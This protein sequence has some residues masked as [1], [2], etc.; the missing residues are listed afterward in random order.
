M[1]GSYGHSFQ[2][3]VVP[4]YVRW[5]G[6]VARSGM[7]NL[8]G[9]LDRMWRPGVVSDVDVQEAMTFTR[10]LQIKRVYKLNDNAKKVARGDPGYDPA[11]KYSMLPSVAVQNSN[12]LLSA[13]CRM[14]CGDETTWGHEGFGE[15]GAGLLFRVPKKPG[16]TKGGQSSLFVPVD[17]LCPVAI[18]HRHKCHTPRPPFN[19]QG[20]HE[21]ML[22]HDELEPL[23]AKGLFGEKLPHLTMD[24]HFADDAV[25]DFLGKEGWS[26]V[27][28]CPRNR[29]PKGVPD[30]FWH[31]AQTAT[32][33]RAK[34]A[35]MLQPIVAVKEVAASGEDK[36]YRRVHVSFQ[37]TGACNI[38]T[39]NALDTVKLFDHQKSRGRGAN[40]ITWNIEMN[41][42]RRLYLDTYGI[43]DT[44]DSYMSKL[45]MHYTSW[46]YWH[47]AMLHYKKMV[48]VMS[49][50]TYS[51][52]AAGKA[53]DK[54]KVDKP[55]GFAAFRERLSAQMM[56]YDPTKLLYPGD[57]LFR[58][59][60][61][62]KK[63]K[64]P[65][66]VPASTESAWRAATDNRKL[67]DFS[68]LGEHWNSVK[69]ATNAKSCRICKEQTLFRCTKCG[70][71]E[72][73]CAPWSNGHQAC[74]LHQHDRGY[75]GLG[76]G[77]AKSTGTEP[78]RWKAPSRQAEKAH[79]AKVATF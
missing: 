63:R 21:V 26:A 18:V 57:N 67:G 41:E 66:T 23:L 39:V 9:A 3:V 48:I 58:S 32:D 6:I 5:D 71:K 14:L 42:A 51:R 68:V 12:A 20:P 70:P 13:I 77:D 17:T 78:K 19:A 44:M 53:G 25:M 65:A 28:T 29:L 30:Q 22:L 2:N 7:Y 76:F 10:F 27:M 37:S 52:C 11:Y 8:Q 60:T 4:E 40:K 47:A 35:R 50:D 64:R 56:A 24:N 69:R 49:Y 74:F 79:R 62:T 54:Y 43:I 31:K 73:V 45:N 59:V 1:G 75:F 61:A 16:V 72:A 46:K 38:S 33:A 15:A 55:L 34:S 36:E